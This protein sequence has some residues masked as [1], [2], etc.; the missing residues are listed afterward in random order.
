MTAQPFEGM[1]IIDAD[2]H[3]TEPHDLW[4]SRAPSAFLDRVPQVRTIDG[5]P[6]WVVDGI[7]LSRAGASG[8]VGRDG[9]KVPGLEFFNWD[10]ED[11]HAGAYSI[12]DRL[13]MMDEQGIWAQIVYPNT[14]GFGGQNFG[15]VADPALRRLAVQIYND[16]MAEMQEESDGSA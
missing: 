13:E 6:M 16:A 7:T 15:K 10:I 11:V 2:T 3:L 8:V 4:T 9:V 12:P 5:T 14:V 1:C